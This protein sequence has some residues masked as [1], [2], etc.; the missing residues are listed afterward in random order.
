VTIDELW[1]RCEAALPEEANLEFYRGRGG[2]LNGTTR[3]CA[4]AVLSDRRRT[5]VRR[6]GETAVDALSALADALETDPMVAK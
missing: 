5:I 3:Y 1:A 2:L 4:W 6:Y